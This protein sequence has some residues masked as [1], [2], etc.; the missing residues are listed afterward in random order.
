MPAGLNDWPPLLHAVHKAQLGT[1]VALLDG[2]AD[3][4]RP[5]A[6]GTTALMMAAGYG[7]GDFAKLLLVIS[8]GYANPRLQHLGPVEKQLVR[9]GPRNLHIIQ[10]RVRA[11]A[12]DLGI[13][14]AELP[15]TPALR[16][17]GS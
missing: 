9:M 7:C 15:A 17:S 16:A 3:V 1:A 8:F 14:A 6:D 4:N 12:N 5:S 10:E 2:G 13:P 11:F